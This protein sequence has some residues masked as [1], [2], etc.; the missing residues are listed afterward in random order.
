MENQDLPKSQRQA[1]VELNLTSQ[2]RGLSST[3]QRCEYALFIVYGVVVETE[4]SQDGPLMASRLKE[5]ICN[6]A[7]GDSK[8]SWIECGGFNILEIQGGL[9]DLASNWDVEKV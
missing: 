2:D 5:D 8:Q 3:V 4:N 1:V 6:V 7:C 9:S